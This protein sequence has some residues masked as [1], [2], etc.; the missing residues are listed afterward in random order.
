[1][2]SRFAVYAQNMFLFSRMLGFEAKKYLPNLTARIM[3][4]LIF[5]YVCNILSQPKGNYCTQQPSYNSQQQK[6]V[7]IVGKVWQKVAVSRVIKMSF[8]YVII[9][10]LTHPPAVP[11]KRV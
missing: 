6:K 1:M 5:F 4:P 8:E 7:Q 10:E 2:V 3:S 11:G 9:Q